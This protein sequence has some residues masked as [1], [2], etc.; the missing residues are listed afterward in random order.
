[1]ISKPKAMISELQPSELLLPGMCWC[2][3]TCTRRDLSWMV[4]RA[5]RHDTARVRRGP[6]LPVATKLAAVLR[7]PRLVQL[8][9]SQETARSRHWSGRDQGESRIVIKFDRCLAR[10]HLFGPSSMRAAN[11]PS[12]RRSMT[13]CPGPICHAVPERGRAN[14][15]PARV[16]WKLS[17]AKPT[18]AAAQALLIDLHGEGACDAESVAV[19][20]GTTR[21]GSEMATQTTTPEAG[22]ARAVTFPTHSPLE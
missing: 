21:H 10:V 8:L 12:N 17:S 4:A 20:V 7:A 14:V 6:G 22:T 1:V 19:Q 13:I 16:S 18:L 2:G 5:P 15:S 11:L 9:K 3:V